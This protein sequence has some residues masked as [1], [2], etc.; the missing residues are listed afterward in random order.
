MGDVL[1]N[2]IQI[3]F[4]ANLNHSLLLKAICNDNDIDKLVQTLEWI[5]QSEFDSFAYSQFPINKILSMLIE[6][7]HKQKAVDIFNSLDD[8]DKS[9]HMIAS[10]MKLHLQNNENEL[11]LMLYDQY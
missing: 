8:N 3:L 5:K 11:A 4:S 6:H 10:M 2:D 7:G 9:E 1:W